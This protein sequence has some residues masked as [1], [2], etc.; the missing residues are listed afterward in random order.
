[1]EKPKKKKKRSKV[2]PCCI[3]GNDLVFNLKGYW[4]RCPYCGTKQKVLEDGY[5]IEKCEFNNNY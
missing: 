1:M 5:T 3:C 2:L 4:I